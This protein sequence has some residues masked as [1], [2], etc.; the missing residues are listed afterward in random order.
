MGEKGWLSRTMW[1]AVA[2]AP[3]AVS[4]VEELIPDTTSPPVSSSI[5]ECLLAR[6]QT[7]CGE[8]QKRGRP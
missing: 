3:N 4:G 1:K 8:S 5:R 7:V 2:G 6:L